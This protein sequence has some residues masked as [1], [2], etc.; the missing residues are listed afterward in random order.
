M[1][2]IHEASRKKTTQMIYTKRQDCEM[3]FQAVDYERTTNLVMMN[4]EL[5]YIQ[6]GEGHLGG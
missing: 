1:K 5:Q 3:S 6:H 4:K 2:Q